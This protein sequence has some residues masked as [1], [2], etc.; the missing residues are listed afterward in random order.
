[1]CEHVCISTYSYEKSG[2][3]KVRSSKFNMYKEETYEVSW[4]VNVY[5]RRSYFKDIKKG[6]KM[7]RK[8]HFL[9][10]KEI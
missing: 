5:K 3:T 4:L 8:F 1:M 6:K 10:N 2:M 7:K 9:T